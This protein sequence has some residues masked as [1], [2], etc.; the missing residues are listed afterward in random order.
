MRRS[1]AVL[2]IEG[3]RRDLIR[4]LRLI[5]TGD[6]KILPFLRKPTSAD[7]EPRSVWS[8]MCPLPPFCSGTERTCLGWNAYQMRYW[9]GCSDHRLLSNYIDCE[10][11]SNRRK[12]IRPIRVIV[13]VR[14][15][16]CP[17]LQANRVFRLPGSIR[18]INRDDQAVD[19]SPS[20]RES[21]RLERCDRRKT[22]PTITTVPMPGAMFLYG[23]LRARLVTPFILF[24]SLS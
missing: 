11:A 9:Q 5:R 15:R 13:D 1:S 4:L 23:H 19:V 10:G 6:F 14:Q 2:K 3:R 12:S 20:A 16:I 22:S 24:S 8:G 7:R 21:C 18:L 17:R